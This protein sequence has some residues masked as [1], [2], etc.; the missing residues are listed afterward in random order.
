MAND[1]E[2]ERRRRGELILLAAQS[3][4]LTVGDREYLTYQAASLKRGGKE[5]FLQ[6]FRTGRLVG[7]V[8]R[9]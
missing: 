6:R 3:K 1:D 8:A 7:R 5:T 4:R 2:E 9:G